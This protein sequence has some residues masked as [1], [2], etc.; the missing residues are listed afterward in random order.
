[1][2]TGIQPSSAVNQVR[3]G[4]CFL[5][6]YVRTSFSPQCLSFLL[7]ILT[8]ME[9]VSRGK[10]TTQSSTYMNGTSDNAVDGNYD[11]TD[12][13]RCATLLH[14]STTRSSQ[15]QVTWEVDLKRLYAIAS[16]TIYNTAVLPGISNAA[17]VRLFTLLI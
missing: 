5:G 7:V 15:Y 13:Q 3:Q 17:A 4:G 8:A 2:I 11:N 1:M 10:N 9:N 6:D 14:A 12:L 16:V